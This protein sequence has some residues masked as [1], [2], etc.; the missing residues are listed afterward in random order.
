[1]GNKIIMSDFYCTQCGSKTLPIWRKKGR[2]REP[3]HLKKLFCLKCGKEVNCVEIKPCNNYGYAEFVEEFE[4]GNFSEEGLRIRPYKELR[5]LID[6]E[7]IQKQKTLVNVRDSGIGEE[8]L[9]SES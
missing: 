2:E 6:N 1:M 5:R 8:H 3:G 9:G 4:Y 7:Q